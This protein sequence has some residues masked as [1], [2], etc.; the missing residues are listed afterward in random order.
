MFFFKKK[1]K[2][3][4]HIHISFKPQTDFIGQSKTPLIG[5]IQR[6]GV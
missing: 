3:D 1:I 5:K 4:Y 2:K 6:S